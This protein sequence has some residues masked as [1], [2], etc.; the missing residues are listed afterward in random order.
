MEFD[1]KKGQHITFTCKRKS[2][3]DTF[4]LHNAEIP[5]TNSVKYLGV[6]LDPKLTSKNLINSITYKG[7]IA[8][9]FIHRKLTTN[10]TEIK[11]TAYKQIVEIA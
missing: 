3:H 8:L 5:Q 6:T 4:W 2:D 1:P 11:C 10:Y 9:G 7:N